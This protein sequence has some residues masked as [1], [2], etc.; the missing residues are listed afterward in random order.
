VTNG[1]AALP[2]VIVVMGVSGAG[3]TT[4]GSM[5]AQRL[6]WEF[7]DADW[8]HPAANVAKMEAGL[9]LTDEDRW[10][11]LEAI[12]AWIDET[13]R[14]GRHGV[15]A[16]SALK[17][18]YRDILI[19]ARADVRLVYLKGERDLIAR[20]MAGRQGHFMPTSL[21]DNQLAT[22]EEPTADERP[23]VV[24]IHVAPETES[25]QVLGELLSALPDR[26]PQPAPLAG[27]EEP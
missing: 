5:L 22:L 27:V 4:I 9:P 23:L 14:A 1:S 21:L 19:G 6:Q 26:P 15:V 11:W 17:R 13:R 10:P 25:E 24:P 7:R 18:V 12:A 3:K 20:R 16:C 8:F 2:A